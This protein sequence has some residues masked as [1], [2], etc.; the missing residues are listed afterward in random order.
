MITITEWDDSKTYSELEA[1]VGWHVVERREDGLM[2]ERLVGQ[3][4]TVIEDITVKADGYKWL[5]V[6]VAKPNKK[7]PTYE[8][9][10]EA[11]RLFIG[12][13]RES[14]MVFPTQDRY[15]NLGNVLHLWCCL[16]YPDGVLPRFE[17]KVTLAGVE[18]LSV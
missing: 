8:D 9:L 3:K 1:P 14:Y 5:H 15:V 7:M 13:D 11:R 10:Q 12:E 16:D 17:G 4:I 2:W 18:M 6:S